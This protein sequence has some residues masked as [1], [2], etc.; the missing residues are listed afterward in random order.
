M[1]LVRNGWN[2]DD[3]GRYYARVDQPR[4]HPRQGVAQA[5]KV[6]TEMNN[7]EIGG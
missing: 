2:V 6:I 5:W 7:Y 1:F 3:G 4:R